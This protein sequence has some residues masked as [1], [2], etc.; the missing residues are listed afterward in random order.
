MKNK[1]IWLTDLHMNNMFPW[2][3][4][5]LISKIKIEQPKGI[6]ITGD[7]S[8]GLWL[9][10][11][12]KMLASTGVD[13]YF[14]NGN[15][16]YHWSSFERTNEKIRELSAIHPNLIWMEDHEII[17][18]D[19]ETCVIGAEDWYSADLGDTKW[20]QFTFDWFLIK[21]FR[22][23][24]DMKARIDAFRER[25][26]VGVKSIERKLKKALEMDYK[27][28]YILLHYPPFLEATRD[29]GTIMERFW[30]PYNTNIRM[31][32][33]IERVMDGRKKRRVHILSGHTHVPTYIRISRSLDCQVGE[34]RYF[35]VPHSQ[36]IYL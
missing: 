6:F 26:N 14:V 3:K 21:E 1:F 27:T 4:W 30:L 25:A 32:K 12:L 36:K 31:G 15:H 8:N 18:L 16:N 28:I 23:M 29:E 34:G 10:H 20:L 5:K 9:S 22:Q 33:M 17:Q 19:E 13:C 35:G 11:D 24:K 2:R 7:I